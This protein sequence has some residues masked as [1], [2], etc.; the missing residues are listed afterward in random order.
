MLGLEAIHH[1]NAIS[2]ILLNVELQNW[3]DDFTQPPC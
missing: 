1:F 2:K 3:N